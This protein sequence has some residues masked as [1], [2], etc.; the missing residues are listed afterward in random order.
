MDDEILLEGLFFQ[1]VR[2][3]NFA[4][5]YQDYLDMIEALRAGYG[6]RS[7][8]SLL[9]LCQTM[10][11]RSAEQQRIIRLIF[12]GIPRPKIDEITQFENELN[13][14]GHD[15]YRRLQDPVNSMDNKSLNEPIAPDERTPKPGVDFSEQSGEGVGL[16][17]A[18]IIKDDSEK[19]VFT[20]RPIFPLR[21]L[22]IAWRRYRRPVR[23]GPK[24]ELDIEATIDERC[25][26]GL[27]EAPILRAQRRNVARLVVLID[28]SQSMRPWNRLNAQLIRSLQ[29][30]GIEDVQ[31]YFFHRIPQDDV[32]LD[33]EM[34]QPIALTTVM[35]KHSNSSVIIFSDAGAGLDQLTSRYLKRLKS[36]VDFAANYRWQPIVFVCPILVR[37]WKKT[38]IKNLQSL[39]QVRVVPLS[40]DGLI[41]AI[42]I[43]RGIR[44]HSGG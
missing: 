3:Y 1:L 26:K 27:L 44:Q 41:E 13:K 22:I 17:R 35:Q 30:S 23:V 11:A 38:S 6:G 12:E 2:E 29:E 37:R 4:L 10:W 24:T 28:L 43:L 36:F 5:G 42:D 15:E 14:L 18:Q 33:E 9:W 34:N 8:A 32:Y 19:F 40:E 39:P 25:R 20:P 16:P 31:C 7:R 21:S